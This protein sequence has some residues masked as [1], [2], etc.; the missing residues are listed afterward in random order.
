MQLEIAR[1]KDEGRRRER[2]REK[3]LSL[4][5]RPLSS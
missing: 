1:K 2:L 3:G 5:E 4:R